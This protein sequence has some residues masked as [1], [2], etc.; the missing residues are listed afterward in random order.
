MKKFNKH[1]FICEN[2][3]AA[4]H[5]KGSCGMCGS[6]QLRTELK[7]K[8]HIKGLKEKI[9]ANTAGCLD[10]CEFGPAM[11]V[12]PEQIW[13]G[14][15]KPE[16]LDEIIESHLVNDIPVERLKIKDE[17]FNRDAE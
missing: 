6:S 3:R 2:I 10:A 8:L 7:K 5:P 15:V 1:I 11:V 4:D 16:D 9:R 17:K 14:N 12:Y 13:Y